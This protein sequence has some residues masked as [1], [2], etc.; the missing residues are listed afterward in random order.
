MSINC[1]SGERAGE[2]GVRAGGNP[3]RRQVPTMSSV[4][5][6]RPTAARG[7]G[8]TRL[9]A[10]SPLQAGWSPCRA[11]AHQKPNSRTNVAL[12]APWIWLQL[13]CHHLR[14][15]R[16]KGAASFSISSSVKW[17]QSSPSGSGE[18]YKVDEPSSRLRLNP[19]SPCLSPTLS[20]ELMDPGGDQSGQLIN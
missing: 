11:P 5:R 2:P 19:R 10:R 12:E 13:K 16:A 6:L 20:A 7:W 9:S 17:G 1:T 8:D 15:L 18:T 14:E 3:S 4:G